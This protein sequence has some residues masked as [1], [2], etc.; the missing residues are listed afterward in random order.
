M[1]EAAAEAGADAIKFQTFKTEHYVSKEN[2]ERYSRLKSF[3]LSFNDFEKLSV[4]ED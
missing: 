2:L 3:E 4:K 1:I